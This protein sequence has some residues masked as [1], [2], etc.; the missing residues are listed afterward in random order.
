MRLAPLAA[1]DSSFLVGTRAGGEMSGDDVRNELSR[2]MNDKSHP[3]HE[4]YQRNDPKVQRHIEE[5]YVKAYGNG[6]V[7]IT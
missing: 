4:G 7:E 6:K 1:Q 5:L 2:I 3:M